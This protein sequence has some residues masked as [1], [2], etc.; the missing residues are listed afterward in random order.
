MFVCLREHYTCFWYQRRLEILLTDN[1]DIQFPQSGNFKNLLTL[2]IRTKSH[3]V[4]GTLNTVKSEERAHNLG[5]LS[6]SKMFH[7]TEA[8]KQIRLQTPRSGCKQ[9]KKQQLLKPVS[10]HPVT[11]CLNTKPKMHVFIII[12]RHV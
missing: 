6:Q 1:E 3:L 11:F 9:T 7:Y 10:K 12:K 2:E 4:R 5:E 8:C